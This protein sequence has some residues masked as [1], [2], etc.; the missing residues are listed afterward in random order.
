[1]VN[2][3]TRKN[4]AK[5]A[6]EKAGR[7]GNCRGSRRQAELRQGGLT[8]KKM[9]IYDVGSR[10]VYENNRNTGIMPGEKSDIYVDTIYILQKSADLDGQF[11]LNSAFAT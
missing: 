3:R 5:F 10:N 4:G 11:C 8:E 1:M 2:W 7:R 6:P 9:L